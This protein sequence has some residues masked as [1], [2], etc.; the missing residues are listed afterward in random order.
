MQVCRGLFKVPDT[1]TGN[2]WS[3]QGRKLKVAI[4]YGTA[5]EN[6]LQIIKGSHPDTT[7]GR[8]FVREQ[9][10]RADLGT[11]RYFGPVV[12]PK[13]PTQ[14]ADFSVKIFRTH[15]PRHTVV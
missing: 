4:F 11:D 5:F 15:C 14:G 2:S 1:I 7:I 13:V 6:M 9:E 3:T 10:H 12:S 8:I